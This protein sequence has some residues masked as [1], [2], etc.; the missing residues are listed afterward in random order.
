MVDAGDIFYPPSNDN[1]DHDVQ[2]SWPVGLIDIDDALR[3]A[4]PPRP[5]QATLAH[6]TAS[7]GLCQTLVSRDAGD[8]D[9]DDDDPSQ[10]NSRRQWLV[11][12]QGFGLLMEV[13]PLT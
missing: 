10:E 8:Q 12:N 11:L 7:C 1:D 4:E 2:Q 9:G 13:T 3:R 5:P 6:P